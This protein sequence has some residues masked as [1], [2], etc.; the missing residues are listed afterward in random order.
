MKVFASK[1]TIEKSVCAPVSKSDAQRFLIARALTDRDKCDFRALEELA[2]SNDDTRAMFVALKELFDKLDK[3]VIDVGE[4]GATLRFLL[5]VVCALGAKA[6]FVGRGRIADR[7]IKELVDTLNAHG[8]KIAGERMPLLAEGKLTSGVYDIVG[9]VS[10]QYVSGLLF[11]LPLID[12]DSEIILKGQ[13]LSSKYVEMTLDTLKRS[14]IRVCR[15]KN[16]FFVKGN[17]DY[18]FPH[19]SDVDGVE[20]DWSSAAVL[21]SIGALCG[22]MLVRG[23][24]TDSKQPD[25]A[26]LDIL[27]RM[28]AHCEINRDCITVHKT[29]LHATDID[30]SQCIDLA[31]IASVL[32]ANAVGASKISGASRLRYK[33]SDRLQGIA[34]MLDSFGIKCDI[35]NDTLMIF[36][37]Q[38]H[39]CKYKTFDHRMAMSAMVFALCTDGESEIDGAECIAKSYPRFLGDISGAKI[40]FS[41]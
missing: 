12:G 7:P 13:L 22:R 3:K 29:Q 10:S 28:G 33:E 21:L 38:A 17:Q 27:K 37:G 40:R 34:Q 18:R 5:P 23:L 20:K 36:G 9:N 19:D 14:G 35:C 32:C 24:S 39:G 6:T 31:P 26:I 4:S 11:A 8:A 25:A 16:G 2:N 1:S 41:E 15:T 30:V